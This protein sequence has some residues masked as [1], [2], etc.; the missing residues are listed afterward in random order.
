MNLGC[1]K[2]WIIGVMKEMNVGSGFR[3]KQK[4][5]ENVQSTL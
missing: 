4:E 3:T 2:I 5:E 1:R